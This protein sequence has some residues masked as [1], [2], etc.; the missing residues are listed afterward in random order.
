MFKYNKVRNFLFKRNLKLFKEEYN[1]D[2]KF[3]NSP[4]RKIK[5]VLNLE[6]AAILIF[7]VSNTKIK[8]NHVTLFGV[9]W[10]YIGT[11]AISSNIDQLIY[12]SLLIYFTK[13]IPDYMDGTLAHLKNEQSKEGYELDLWAGEINKIGV[14]SGVIIYI[15]NT[16]N[17]NYYLY[18]LISII[19]LNFIDPRK[20]ISRTKF[21]ISKYKDKVKTHVQLIK[22]NDN[23]LLKFMKFLNFD[24]RTNYSDFVIFLILLDINFNLNLLLK[25]LPFLWLTL[26]F[27][28]LIRAKYLVFFKK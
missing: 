1:W 20:H 13:L 2:Y 27:L 18:I 21:G 3:L 10:V 17:Q 16:T 22:K 19:L 4:Y 26:S 5:T 12:I 9:L 8:A 7:F 28:V 24:D 25:S 6:I 15:Y 23:F 14:I 11:I